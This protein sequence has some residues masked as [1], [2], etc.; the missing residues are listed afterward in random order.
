MPTDQSAA[1]RPTSLPAVCPSPPGGA[2]NCLAETTLRLESIPSHELKRPLR[3]YSRRL[4][5]GRALHQPIT[6][7]QKEDVTVPDPG[8]ALLEPSAKIPEPETR[9]RGSILSYFKPVVPPRP[10]DITTATIPDGIESASTLPSLPHPLPIREPRKRRRLTTRPQFGAEDRGKMDTGCGTAVD[11]SNER[12]YQTGI[13]EHSDDDTL[14]I[15]KNTPQETQDSCGQG[16]RVLDELTATVAGQVAMSGM[17]TKRPLGITDRSRKRC[18][19]DMVQTTLSLSVNPD[20]GFTVCKD[21]GILYNPLNEKDRKE[22]KTR[23][24][25]HARSRGRS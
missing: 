10:N 24:A 14:P 16:S 9:K 20:P 12:S 13:N 3:T 8:D 4:A 17:M 22:H 11:C 18:A 23:H 1:T 19:K 21:C 7:G 15:N 2:G 5:S 6:S 25:A